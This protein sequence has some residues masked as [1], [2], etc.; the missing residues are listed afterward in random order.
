MKKYVLFFVL[1]IV[2]LFG[3]F[4]ILQNEKIYTN[5]F[6]KISDNYENIEGNR[7]LVHK[8]FSSI[9]KRN[10]IQWDAVH[11]Q[12]IKENGYQ[13]S[14]DRSDKDD[15]IFAFFPLFPLIWKASGLTG[16]GVVFLNYFLF[17]ISI[18]LLIRLLVPEKDHWFY[19]VLSVLLPSMINFL[20]PYTESTFLLMG[21]IGIIGLYRDKY[22]LYFFGM[23][24]VAMARPSFTFLVLAL[25]CVEFFF[26]ISHLK[27]KTFFKN[28]FL[29][30]IPL[31]FGTFLVMLIQ[32]LY[33][34]PKWFSFVEVQAYWKNEFRIPEEISDWSHEGFAMDIVI[35]F[36][37]FVPFFASVIFWLWNQFSKGQIKILNYHCKK[38]YLLLLS[39]VYSIGTVLFV[40]LFRGGGLQGLYRFILNSPFTFI[41]LFIG[42]GY[43][44]KIPKFIQLSIF[45]FL[46]GYSIYLLDHLPY[47]QE[48][49]YSYFGGFQIVA[50]LAFWIFQERKNENWYKFSLLLLLFANVLWTSFLLNSY[51]NDSWIFA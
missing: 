35:L 3:V 20:I 46:V 39:I 41:W 43:W 22:W 32:R 30:I 4:K 10:I 31:F 19:L 16:I 48:W 5:S 37:L 26:Y 2:V 38:D 27:L 42:F 33:D 36:V 40:M 45:G 47:A 12:R 34:S 28:T 8:P 9:T 18:F 29:K 50:I 13:Y 24:G 17:A 25:I 11:Y 23:T 7:K 44:K 49:N 21:T 51:I 14:F 6:G 15:Y 1:F